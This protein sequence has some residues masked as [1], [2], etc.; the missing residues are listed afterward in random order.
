MLSNVQHGLCIHTCVSLFDPTTLYILHCFDPTASICCMRGYAL[1]LGWKKKRKTAMIL[2]VGHRAIDRGPLDPVTPSLI[3]TFQHSM[4]LAANETGQKELV[5]LCLCLCLCL[6][7]QLTYFH[8]K[9]N[10]DH[11]ATV[12]GCLVRR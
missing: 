12:D 10:A 6:L 4:I 3:E 7:W 8:C 2:I 11:L 5:C 9:I 1:A